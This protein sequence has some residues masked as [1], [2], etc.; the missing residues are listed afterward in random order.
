M[1][2][3]DKDGVVPGMFGGKGS[4]EHLIRHL[5][6]DANTEGPAILMF[7][8][9]RGDIVP[10]LLNISIEDLCFF[11]RILDGTITDLMSGND[12]QESD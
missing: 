2:E 9:K 10:V 4:V 6:E 1:T 3:K 8:D 12:W 5:R 7:E 11:S